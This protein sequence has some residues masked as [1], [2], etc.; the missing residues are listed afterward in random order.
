MIDYQFDE[1]VTIS[2]DEIELTGRL[3]IPQQARGV[4]VFA[5]GS[6]SSRHSPRNQ[7]VAQALQDTG[8]A[9]LLFDLLTEK[10]ALDNAKKFEIDLLKDR[11]IK[12]SEWFQADPKTTDLNM[13][14]FGASTGAAAALEA[15]AVLGDTV[16]AVVCRGGR[17]DLAAHVVPLVKAPTL[18]LVG[19]FDHEVITLNEQA[20]S[21]LT[22]EK[23]LIIVEEAT[24]L[25][26]E[27]GKLEEVAVHAD[28]WFHEHLSTIRLPG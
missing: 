10:E 17:P 9:T 14:Y 27:P 11:L 20:F 22:C 8:F 1:D 23:E 16:K 25:F 3:S 18:L 5:H 19:G 2:V 24:H 4:V 13:G 21:L 26:D 6:G 12:V 28:N 7:F 15:A